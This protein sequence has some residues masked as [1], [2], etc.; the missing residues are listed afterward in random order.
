M[1]LQPEPQPL[2]PQIGAAVTLRP[3][4]TEVMQ[5]WQDVGGVEGFSLEWMLDRMCA[6]QEALP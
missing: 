5:R 6:S 2:M 3:T 1:R 4:A